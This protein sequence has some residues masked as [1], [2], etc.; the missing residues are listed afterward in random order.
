M[1]PICVFD[2]ETRAR[3]EAV[4]ALVE[5]MQG[6]LDAITA[7]A[8]WK[9]ETKIAAYVAEKRAAALAKMPAEAALDPDTAQ[10]VA[11]A[12]RL[13]PHSPT[14]AFVVGSL[15][16]A[17]EA[18]LLTEL[19]LAL[20]EMQGRCAGFN[21]INFDLPMIQRRSMTLGVTPRLVPQVRRYATDPVCDL[22]EVYFNWGRLKYKSMKTVARLL[23]IPNPLA[24]V[25]RS[26]VAVMDEAAL[27]TYVANDVDLETSLWERMDGIYWPRQRPLT[28]DDRLLDNETAWLNSNSLPN[29]KRNS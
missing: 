17:D 2:I 29:S 12:F 5:A 15:D 7:P 1:Q 3:P 13:Y 24:G 9:D 22:M 6:E 14:R 4:A 11:V 16:V 20:A 18:D 10:I 21:I 28:L 26:Q 27:L 8:N 25:D 19:W 23:G